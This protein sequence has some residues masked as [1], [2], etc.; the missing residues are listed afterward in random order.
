MEE[1]KKLTYSNIVLIFTFR[2]VF[3]NADFETHCCTLHTYSNRNASSRNNTEH[4][5]DVRDK[6][7]R[8]RSEGRG[9][10]EGCSASRNDTHT[11]PKTGEF[12]PFN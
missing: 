11:S 5:T 9:Q 10:L 8:G 7:K 1:R 2:Y 6:K 3:L 12:H 4:D